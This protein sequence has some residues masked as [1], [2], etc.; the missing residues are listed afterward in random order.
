MNMTAMVDLNTDIL[1]PSSRPAM[2]DALI[3]R[4]G[5]DQANIEANPVHLSPDRTSPA[6]MSGDETIFRAI[7]NS[8]K[9]RRKNP[10]KAGGIDPNVTATQRVIV[11]A[12][13][14]GESRGNGAPCLPGTHPTRSPIAEN[15]GEPGRDQG[16]HCAIEAQS[17]S[18]PLIAEITQLVR[19]RRRWHKAEKSLTLQ[20]KALCRSW[21]SGDKDEAN[22]AYDRAVAGNPDDPALAM[23][24]A[25]FLDA[26]ARFEVEREAIEKTLRKLAKTLP[27]WTSWALGVKG[28][29]ELRLAVIVGECGDI[30]S[31][32]NPSCLWKRMGLAVIGDHRQRRVSDASDALE[33]GYNP[34]R[35]A[36][37]YVM[38]TEV[39][40]AQV[41]NVKDDDGKRTDTSTAIGPY[42]QLYLD[43]KVYEAGREGITKAHANNR[44]ARYMV[45]RVLRDLYAAWSAAQ[46]SA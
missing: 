6:A 7:P 42:G 21:T 10:A 36:I 14:S 28:L 25:P 15:S 35:R 32:R 3:P 2:L 16:T 45:K 27:V 1:T 38:G 30:G 39:L 9:S 37:A 43:R 12:N 5:G 34:E 46:V 40:K 11:D 23:A 19:M 18:S 41:R 29:G 22:A 8:A 44:A 26:K 24:L 4:N 33:H 13:L 17:A 31:Y 20:G